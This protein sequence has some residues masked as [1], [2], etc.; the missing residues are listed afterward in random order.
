MSGRWKSC[1]VFD[2]LPC[3]S[4]IGTCTQSGMTIPRYLSS[5]MH[6]GKLPE[7]TELQ[8]RTV[9]FRKEVCPKAKNPTLQWIME[10]EEG[11]HHSEIDHAQ[12]FP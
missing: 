2:K 6:L 7:H 4:G 8:G 11:T 12:R 3:F 5:E 1:Y 10:I 9:N